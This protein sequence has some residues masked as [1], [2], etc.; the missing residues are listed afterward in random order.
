MSHFTNVGIDAS[1]A[2]LLAVL[3][4][5]WTAVQFP[6]PL[7]PGCLLQI[8]LNF[9]F[10]SVGLRCSRYFPQNIFMVMRVKGDTEIRWKQKS[11]IL[12]CYLQFHTCGHMNE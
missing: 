2:K 1:R 12:T 11:H 7:S 9:S 3:E 10:T 4:I 5:N 6:R 8:I